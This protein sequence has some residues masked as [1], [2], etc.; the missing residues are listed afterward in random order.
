LKNPAPELSEEVFMAKNYSVKVENG[1]V[2]VFGPSGEAVRELCKNAK[3]A[4]LK[5]DEVNVTTNEN[6]I[7]VYSVNGFYKKTL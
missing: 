2:K 1:T 3:T 6:K 5:G 4:L 7:K